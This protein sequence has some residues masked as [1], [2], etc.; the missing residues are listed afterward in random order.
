VHVRKPLTLKEQQ[1]FIVSSLPG[2]GL[3]TAKLLL[4]HFG[5]IKKLFDAS[6]EEMIAIDGIG[7]KTSTTIKEV[8]EGEYKKE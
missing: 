5:S 3:N 1:E 4:E 7:E 8:L 6:K 2:I